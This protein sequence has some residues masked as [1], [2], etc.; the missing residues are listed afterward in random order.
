MGSSLRKQRSRSNQEETSSQQG[1]ISSSLNSSPTDVEDATMSGSILSH[2]KEYEF[3][4]Q[5]MRSVLDQ[6]FRKGPFGFIALS[7]ELESTGVE[8]QVVRS[9]LSEKQTSSQPQ[10][11][12]IVYLANECLKNQMKC[13]YTLFTMLASGNDTFCTKLHYENTGM[14]TYFCDI[15]FIVNNHNGIVE[16]DW[17]QCVHSCKA[18]LEQVERDTSP[19][20]KVVYMTP[21]A[22]SLCGVLSNCV[23][24][25]SQS[26]QQTIPQVRFSFGKTSLQVVNCF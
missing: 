21:Q 19:N 5:V 16:D 25:T 4:R 13:Q 18:L 26:Q 9:T 15:V 2:R 17:K 24:L 22:M 12:G 3:S 6:V 8:N 23:S 14:N 1:P 10:Q 7:V 20:S 11:H